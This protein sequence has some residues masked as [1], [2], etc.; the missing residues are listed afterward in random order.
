MMEKRVYKFVDMVEEVTRMLGGKPEKVTANYKT[1]TYS[2]GNKVVTVNRMF[3]FD[4]ESELGN[5]WDV[6]MN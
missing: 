4:D 3:F 2:R 1:E 5:I 6:S